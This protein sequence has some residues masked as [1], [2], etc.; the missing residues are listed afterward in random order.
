[1]APAALSTLYCTEEDLQNLLSEEGERLRLDDQGDGY[2]NAL[3][4]TALTK[5]ISYAT[6]RVNFYCQPLY[7]TADLSTSWLANEWATIIAT[8]WLCTR[9]GNPC[10]DSIQKMYDEALEDL[11]AVKAGSHQIPDLG[12]RNVAWPAW[13]NV[14]VRPEYHYRKQRVQRP[15]SEQTPTQYP[16]APDWQAEFFFEP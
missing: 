6:T 1:M 15:I 16:Q 3:E 7:A 2:L 8:R 12:Y 4:R 9:R 5:A 13:S 10:P 14:T 11:Q